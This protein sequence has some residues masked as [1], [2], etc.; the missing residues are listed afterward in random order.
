[1]YTSIH[2]TTKF[3]W[4]KSKITK[5]MLLWPWHSP[6]FSIPCLVLPGCP[7]VALKGAS[8]LQNECCYCNYLVFILQRDNDAPNIFKFVT[9]KKQKMINNFANLFAPMGESFNP[10][11]GVRLRPYNQPANTSYRIVDVQLT[12]RTALYVRTPYWNLGK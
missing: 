12:F 4:N 6:L 10:Y 1:M 5:I 2:F 11:S 9:K 8:L 3:R 7:L